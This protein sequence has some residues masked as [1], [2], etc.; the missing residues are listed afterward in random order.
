M[1]VVGFDEDP[2]TDLND[3]LGYAGFDPNTAGKNLWGKITQYRVDTEVNGVRIVVVKYLDEKIH[4]DY[5]TLIFKNAIPP[6]REK[7]ELFTKRRVEQ[8]KDVV[9]ELVFRLQLTPENTYEVYNFEDMSAMVFLNAA[10]RL[11]AFLTRGDR[12]AFTVVP[13]D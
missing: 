12:S 8:V 10:P 2:P 4:S 5:L 3:I 9:A 7:D 13:D 11:D 6:E 1:M